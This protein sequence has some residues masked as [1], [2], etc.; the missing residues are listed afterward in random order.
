M[1]RVLVPTPKKWVTVNR[2]LPGNDVI[3]TTLEPRAVMRHKRKPVANF[4]IFEVLNEVSEMK[5]RASKDQA[6]KG[7]YL[8]HSEPMLKA[9]PAV[10]KFL[11]DCWYDDGQGRELSKLTIS[12]VPS[13]VS[14]ALSDPGERASAFTTAESLVEAL[15]LLEAAIAG[16]GDPWRPWP[17]S[18]GK[19]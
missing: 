3:T 19:K 18:F 11:W 15:G 10:V 5:R 7:K 9:Y 13:G 1:K 4:T 17:K 8:Q 12:L 14:I 16:T 6:V 2:I